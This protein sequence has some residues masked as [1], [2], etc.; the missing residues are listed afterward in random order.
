MLDYV[1]LGIIATITVGLL[2]L[3][4]HVALS[5]LALC[6]GSVLLA[7]SGENAGLVVVS[8]TSGVGMAGTVIKLSLLLV[9]PLVV[10]VLLR[11][12]A[13]ASLFILSLIVALATAM[14]AILL[15]VPLLDKAVADEISGTEVWRQ[16]EAFR[17]LII[18]G[19]LIISVVLVALTQKRA[20]TKHG[21][22]K[23]R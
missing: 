4:T 16:L 19:G 11:R 10:S 12:Q 9:P 17:E 20:E 13:H 1:L 5:F 14:L 18:G 15:T 7:S 23:H 8:L 6:A 21:K 2:A 3:R 22:S